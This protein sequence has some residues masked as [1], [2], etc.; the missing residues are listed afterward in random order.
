MF[1]L[2]SAFS[3]KLLVSAVLITLFFLNNSSHTFFLTN[4][5]STASLNFLKSTGTSFN[6]STSSLSNSST[7]V[8]KLAKSTFF[9]KSDVWMIPLLFF[10]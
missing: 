2:F 3:T 10:K 6:W 8:F 7:V 9:A 1:V 4:Y 5:F